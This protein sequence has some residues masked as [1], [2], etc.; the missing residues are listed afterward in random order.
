MSQYRDGAGNVVEEPDPAVAE[1]RGWTPVAP[2]ETYAS[3]RSDAAAQRQEELGN[4]P[5]STLNSGIQ[6]A[7]SALTVGGSDYLLSKTLSGNQREQVLAA[8]EAHPTAHTVGEVG[9]MIAGAFVDPLAAATPAGYLS[10]ATGALAETGRAAGGVRG[11]LTQ[12]AASGAEGAVQNAGQYLGHAALADSDVTAEGL[13]GA[14]GTGFAFGAAG[15]GVALGVEKGSIAARRLFS[16]VMDGGDNAAATATAEWKTMGENRIAA[17][18]ATADAA[19]RELDGLRAAENEARAAQQ[20]AG[21]NVK[22]ELGR[23]ADAV[24]SDTAARAAARDE[25]I[26]ALKAQAAPAAEPATATAKADLLA[27]ETALRAKN[28]PVVEAKP[29]DAAS[30]PEPVAEPLPKFK[31]RAKPAPLESEYAAGREAAGTAEAS[32]MPAPVGKRLNI[33]NPSDIEK[34]VLAESKARLEARSQAPEW[35][36]GA[37]AQ[38]RAAELESALADF[39]RARPGFMDHLQLGG[40][41]PLA[42][43]AARTRGFPA[44]EA[45]PSRPMM[46]EP[47]EILPGEGTVV[48]KRGALKKLDAAHEDALARAETAAPGP[49]REAAVAE[50]RSIEKKLVDAAAPDNLIG[51]VAKAA[52][53][54]NAYEKA[55]SK[56][57]DVV[58]EG[59]HPASA[60]ASAAFKAAQDEASRKMMNRTGQ[61]AEDAEK[62]GPAERPYGPAEYPGAAKMTPAQRVEYARARKGEADVAAGN[63]KVA[64]TEGQGRYDASRATLRE[65]KKSV[66][67]AKPEAPPKS[68]ASR[69]GGGLMGA[70]MV[71]EL[72]NIPGIPKPHDIPVVG[73]LLGMYLKYRAAKA[74]LGRFTGRVPATADAR[75]ASLASRTRDRVATAVD[76][77][78][79][80]TEKVAPKARQPLVAIGT[81]LS[82]R[83]YDDGKPELPKSASLPEHAAARIGEI[84]AY[85]AS[86]T[87][88]QDDVRREL[89]DV[90]DPDVIDAAVKHRIAAFNYVL[91]QLPKMPPPNILQP[92]PQVPSFADSLG[93]GRRLQVVGNPVSAFDAA[94]DGTLTVEGADTMKN[95]FPKLYA[96][97]QQRLMDHVAAGSVD[98]P[99]QT[100]QRLRLLFDL[101]HEPQDHA[102]VQGIYESMP[103]TLA[104]PASAP[105]VPSIAGNTSLNALSQLPQDRSTLKR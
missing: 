66:L 12:I 64:A 22:Q 31:T 25:Q 77:A 51:D 78:L 85:V 1:R 15:G 6:G 39:E 41:E 16:R 91:D 98:V 104:G 93:F 23:Q 96:Q 24:T 7:L 79:G 81:A 8:Q 54:I 90:T 53:E 11:A 70:A 47:T 18:Q 17:D 89:R 92:R 29:V 42:G 2:E 58:G 103:A 21:V 67:A 14:A 95:V 46:R 34:S 68:V 32:G 75:V 37:K 48:G 71:D 94:A 9:G 97:A 69:A 88:I 26:A 30:T 49:A 73:P 62:F 59:A 3:A 83:I 38:A 102:I 35:A 44:R 57:A 76:R 74:V 61:A 65:T 5:G 99:Y 45:S 86:P 19:R 55:S 87:A 13:A 56:M 43:D 36:L 10:K 33:E 28:A 105:P 40:G 4:L 101:P 60:E 50:A 82:Q 72:L 80:V 52:P 27:E 63:A 100:Q 84:S 20:R